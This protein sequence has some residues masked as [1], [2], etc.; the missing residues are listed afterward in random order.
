MY[1][2]YPSTSDWDELFAYVVS[3]ACISVIAV[4][5]GVKI[6]DGRLQN[7]S[8]ITYPRILV[9]ML[10]FASWAFS[11]IS[12]V[13]IVTN[14]GMNPVSFC[15]LPSAHAY[16]SPPDGLSNPLLVALGNIISCNLTILACNVDREGVGRDLYRHQANENAAVQ[17]PSGIAD[18]GQHH[19]TR[20]H[21]HHRFSAPCTDNHL[22][23]QSCYITIL[24]IRPLLA[25]GRNA[26]G[27]WSRSILHHVAWR[28]AIAAIV[29]LVV[30]AVNILI[31]V[32]FHGHERGLVCLTSCTVDV[33]LNVV[34]VHWVRHIESPIAERGNGDA[35]LTDGDQRRHRDGHRTDVAWVQISAQRRWAQRG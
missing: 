31:L 34:A 27:D 3:L 11:A 5:F 24:F 23:K 26:P 20:R 19:R 14:D 10:Y 25:V 9:L 28:N 32:L 35:N 6:S 13:L 18:A 16:S 33:T 1:T 7:L 17:I 8:S 30:S 2:H 4:L 12:M 22:G 15:N 29:C 21:L